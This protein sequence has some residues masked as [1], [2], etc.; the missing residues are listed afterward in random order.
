MWESVR[1]NDKNEDWLNIWCKERNYPKVGKPDT[2]QMYE[3]W[4]L[5]DGRIY[6]F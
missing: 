5:K 2:A 1:S 6:Y 3:K 4:M